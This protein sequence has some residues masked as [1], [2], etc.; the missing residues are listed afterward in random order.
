MRHVARVARAAQTVAAFAQTLDADHFVTAARFL[1]DACTYD[2]SRETLTGAAAILASYAE[3]S[4]WAH[5]TFEQVRYRSLLEPSDG[6]DVPI[7]FVDVLVRGGLR[8]EHRCRQTFS[9][10]PQGTI[11]R[12]VHHELPGERER[13]LEF[14]ERCGV[15]R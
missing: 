2:T 14:F 3:N 4:S 5:E 8:H 12:I 1:A 10:G 6:A 9:V 7:T 11:A 13:L 15:T